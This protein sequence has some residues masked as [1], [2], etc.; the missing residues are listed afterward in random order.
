M[1][2]MAGHIKY[3]KGSLIAFGL[4]CVAGLTQAYGQPAPTPTPVPTPT[5]A[6]LSWPQF[7]YSPP[8]TGN[9]APFDDPN[10]QLKW[11]V[12]LGNARVTYSS[13]PVTCTWLLQKGWC[14]TD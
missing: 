4:L 1:A 10:F 12:S 5:P 6:A 11:Q 2:V 14:A 7:R 8:N 9:Y 3:I 13:A